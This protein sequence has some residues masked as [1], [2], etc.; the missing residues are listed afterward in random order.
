M[1]GV[2]IAVGSNIGDGIKNCNEAVERL[3]GF[4]KVGRVSPY[5][6]TKPWGVDDIEELKDQADFIN[7]VVEVETELPPMELL[8]ALKAIERDM[9]RTE[10]K[11][12][13]PRLIDLDI[14]FYGDEIIDS[15]ELKV[16]HTY[17]HE[18][19]FVL[20]PLTD[21]APDVIHPRLGRTA[22]ELLDGLGDLKDIERV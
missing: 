7:G 18:R 9:G 16:P 3:K 14:I 12:W 19:A 11:R 6:K 17:M 22:R 10:G 15:A 21:I 4:T 13:G 5:Y 1:K 2:F 20:K 8:A